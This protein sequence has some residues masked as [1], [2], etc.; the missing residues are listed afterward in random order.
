MALPFARSTFPGLSA[1]LL[2]SAFIVSADDLAWSHDVTVQVRDTVAYPSVPGVLSIYLTNTVDTIAGLQLLLQIDRPDLIQFQPDSSG[3]TK[4]D[5]TGTALANWEFVTV[6]PQGSGLTTARVIGIANTVIPPYTPGIAP[7]PE[8]KL[9][10]KIPFSTLAASD[11]LTDRTANI[12][13]SHDTRYCQFSDEQ[14]VSLGIASDTIVDT[15]CFRC[16]QWQGNIC[17][18][19]T[20]VSAPPCDSMVVDSTFLPKL[21]TARLALLD[22]AVTVLPGCSPIPLA[23]DVDGDGTPGTVADMTALIRYVSTGTPP[24][25]QPR[26]ADVDGDCAISFNDVSLIEAKFI[27]GQ[28]VIFAAC[29]CWDPV[30]RCCVGTRGNVDTDPDDLIDV[31]DLT[32]L[33]AF[34]FEHGLAPGCPDEANVNGDAGGAIDIADLPYLI[35]YLFGG[36][37]RPPSCP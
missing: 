19:W 37:A 12:L 15:L 18:Q 3:N 1:F 7:S 23:G 9:L 2:A 13:I 29:T 36:G 30:R 5:R 33:T 31:A 28:P 10:L 11:T 24:L 20:A 27:Q 21:D 34:L 14:G 35:D 26:N 32:Y 6:K 22:G 25:A 17:L 8:P 16:Q 4:F